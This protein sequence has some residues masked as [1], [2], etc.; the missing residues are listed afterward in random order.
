MSYDKYSQL[1]TDNIDKL[2][3]NWLMTKKRSRTSENAKG[4][5]LKYSELKMADYLCPSDENISIEEQKW[6]FKCRVDD[7]DVKANRRWQNDEITC[8]SC[9]TNSDETQMHILQCK[10]LLEKS[11]IFTYIPSYSE[12]FYGDIQDQVYVSRLI[13]D[14][15]GRRIV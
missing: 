7:I 12:L 15:H 5:Y 9:N 14:N 13:K 1:L 10:S 4:K 2:A 11:Q 6:L 3:F 8:L